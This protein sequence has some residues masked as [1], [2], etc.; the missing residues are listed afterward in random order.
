MFPEL[1]ITEALERDP[2]NLGISFLPLKKG[3]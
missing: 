3:N 2:A 1:S